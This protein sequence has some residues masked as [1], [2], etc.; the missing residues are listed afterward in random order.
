MDLEELK[1]ELDQLE[2]HQAI[3]IERDVHEGSYHDGTGAVV[4]IIGTRPR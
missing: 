3:E 1:R 2:L 4:Q